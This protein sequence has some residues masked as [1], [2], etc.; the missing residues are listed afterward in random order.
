MTADLRPVTVL[1]SSTADVVYFRKK[2]NQWVEEIILDHPF[3]SKVVEIQS[4]VLKEIFEVQT[5][6]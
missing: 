4:E 1:L 5:L 3:N 2:V 6:S